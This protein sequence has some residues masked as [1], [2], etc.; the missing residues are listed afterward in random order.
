MRAP[1]RAAAVAGMLASSM[2]GGPA[3]AHGDA[4]EAR[5]AFSSAGRILTIGADGSDRRQ[6]SGPTVPDAGNVDDG[7]PAWPPDG[8]TIAF[9]RTAGGSRNQ[10]SGIYLMDAD[11]S[12][13]RPLTSSKGKTYDFDPQW[14]PDGRWVVFA[15]L[16][17]KHE[18]VL[19]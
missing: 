17:V 2:A 7:Y 10:T 9:V 16:S 12:D 5:I 3:V 19:T 15:R 18:Q 8:N 6:I 1:Y 4:G 13:Q 11:G 14:S